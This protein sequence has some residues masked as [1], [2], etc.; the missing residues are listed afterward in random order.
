MIRRVV[1]FL[2][3]VFLLSNVY[4]Q[5]SPSLPMKYPW[6]G[7]LNSCQF[8]NIDLNLDG[9]PDLVI[10][11]R[12]GN[13]ILPFIAGAE[14]YT[15]EPSYADLFPDLHDWVI[16]AD[17]DKDGRTDIFTYSLGGVRVFRNVSGTVLK[18]QLVTDLLTSFYYTGYVGI[19]LTPVDYPAIAD[20]DG[21]GDLDLL[22]FFG[23]GSY[24]EYHKNLSMEKYGNADSLDFRLTDNC[25]GDF[26]ESEGGNH[27]Q[28]NIVCPNKYL[29]LPGVSC[30]SQRDPKHTGSTLWA[31]DLDGSGTADLVIGDVDFP[32]LVALYNGGTPDSAHMVS[33][34]SLFPG[35][36]NTVRV[37]TF[38]VC[39]HVYTDNPNGLPDLIV[40][41]FDP[42][43]AV[44]ENFS[45]IWQYQNNGTADVPSYVLTNKRFMQD[46]MIDVGSN[47]FPVLYDLDGDGLTD[48]VIGNYGY[49]DSAWS[50]Q[51][52]RHT[53][54]TS[55]IA[56]YKNTG[57]A[58]QP[59]FRE[60]TKD[61]AGLS[62]LHLTGFYPAF[63]DLDGDGDADMVVGNSDGTLIYLENTAGPGHDPAYASPLRHYQQIDVGDFST[64]QL[65]D[66]DKDGLQ[67]LVI[68]EKNGNLDYYRNTG[69]A[70]N[71]VFTHVTDSLGHVNVT[72][73]AISYDGYSTPCFFRT[74]QGTTRLLCGSEE[75]KI[76]Y[77]TGI[78]GNLGGKFTASDSLWQLLSDTAFTIR[79]GWRTAAAIL[80]SGTTAPAGL[81]VGNYSGGLNY[82]SSITPPVVSGVNDLPFTPTGPEFTVFPDP[83]NGSFT[84]SVKGSVPGHSYRADL[85]NLAGQSV[86][87]AVLQQTATSFQ[88]GSLPAGF[89][90]V[91]I[92]EA[93][94]NRTISSAFRKVIILH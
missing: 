58:A 37:E 30:S 72:N 6:A 7:G 78:D 4:S 85:F 16:F 26:K 14:G 17:Y 83:A 60:M 70:M 32:N 42:Q 67:D 61:L 46:E 50:I 57:T 69:T 40:S 9:L 87:T 59:S 90:L 92:T 43:T 47:A 36:S 86:L 53:A 68:G 64:P 49:F 45:S 74:S 38:P 51:G 94:H 76:H 71:P 44:S 56:W 48:L 3:S 62:S 89:Y 66:L 33:M 81:I 27:I 22:S 12:Q 13:R 1:I 93:V 41:P 20:I 2:L 28:L 35:G 29:T 39:S 84:V 5:E 11:D 19:L 54:F 52:I 18:F 80:L 55:K 34:D 63:A 88:T 15:L 77:Y 24:V 79:A 73:S 23:L 25:F 65:F 31:T 21:D 10:F 8:G 91:K 82:Y 75:G